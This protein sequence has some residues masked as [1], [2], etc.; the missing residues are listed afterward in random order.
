MQE[1]APISDL[2][3]N[4]KVSH[5]E[6]RAMAYVDEACVKVF[7]RD[8]SITEHNPTLKMEPLI[9]PWL[10]RPVQILSGS[11]PASTGQVTFWNV[12]A[13]ELQTREPWASKLQNYAGIRFDLVF[14]VN[15]AATPFHS[16]IGRVGWAPFFRAYEIFSQSFPRVQSRQGVYQLPGYTYNLSDVTQICF[17]VPWMNNIPYMGLEENANG[18]YSEPGTFILW[19]LTDVTPPAGTVAPTYNVF[20]HLENV[21]VI[22]PRASAWSTV[23][24]QMGVI[25]DLR[26]SRAISR[27]LAAAGTAATTMGNIPI[28]PSFVGQAGWLL[29]RASQA[30][31]AFGFS[32]PFV[33]TPLTRTLY[34]RGAF[35]TNATGEDPAA[36]VSIL[37]DSSVP[38]LPVGGTDIDEQSVAYIAKFPGLINDFTVDSQAAGTLIYACALCPQAMFFQ[39]NRLN[40]PVKEF[41]ALMSIAPFPAIHPS[42]VF[43]VSSIASYWSGSFDFTFHLSKTKFHT[44]RLAFVF[45]P[46]V[47]DAIFNSVRGTGGYQF[48]AYASTYMMERTIVD[49]RQSTCVKVHTPWVS[50]H[51]MQ[52]QQSPYGYLCVYIVDPV[53]SPATVTPG[54]RVLVD[55]TSPDLVLSGI[56]GTTFAPTLNLNNVV[57]QCWDFE[58][59]EAGLARALRKP[60]RAPKTNKN[61]VFKDVEPLPPKQPIR[62]PLTDVFEPQMMGVDSMAGDIGETITSMNIVA[63][64]TCLRAR[65]AGTSNAQPFAQNLPTYTPN[66]IAPTAC[67]MRFV[68]LIDY[69]RSAYA[70][71]RGG[72][73]FQIS[74]GAGVNRARAGVVTFGASGTALDRLSF[75]NGDVGQVLEVDQAT[76][77]ARIYVP[78]YSPYA[79]YK[80][81]QGGLTNIAGTSR[82]IGRIAP[83]CLYNYGLEEGADA[84]H[85]SGRAVADDHAF[86]LFVGWPPLCRGSFT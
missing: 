86:M 19:N 57:A 5:D 16:G 14:T 76:P 60:Y 72:M 31:A 85:T 24:P 21:S 53:R 75:N 9:A 4:D 55:V 27:V 44:G 73:I 34:Q 63:K 25:E 7:A 45:I 66:L 68:D 29:S 6:G 50:I 42:P 20:V 77:Y 33:N 18:R 62:P 3:P 47:Q 22:G 48:P 51:P 13:Q 2:T 10:E 23:Q 59:E 61:K 38:V 1:A 46:G 41:D 52:A 35:Q 26:G 43:G 71:E 82:E 56:T 28:L 79:C 84:P 83:T 30:A 8:R 67:S 80:T 49:I 74:A 65:A 37:H 39:T 54:V 81:D 17:R 70:L 78:R 36:N 64:R 32:K 11:L 15:I 58:G 12:T 40:L 69:V